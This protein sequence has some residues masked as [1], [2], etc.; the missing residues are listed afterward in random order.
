MTT[1]TG[2]LAMG[3][4]FCPGRASHG[5]SLRAVSNST[6]AVTRGIL[7]AAVVLTLCAAAPR[8]FGQLSNPGFEGL[9]NVVSISTIVA[10]LT[11]GYWGVE[12]AYVTTASY[13][14]PCEGVQMLEMK[15]TLA[16]VYTEAWQFIDVGTGSG[17]TANLSSGFN[18]FEPS[19]TGLLDLIFY[20]NNT[21]GG[22][23]NQ[24]SN[25]ATTVTLDD[26]NNAWEQ[27][28]LN[29][30]AVPDA[31]TWVGVHLGFTNASIGTGTFGLADVDAVEF[32]I[33]P[34]PATL[35]LLALGGLAVIR[36]RRK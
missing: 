33:T 34:E 6:V 36:R 20:A 29:N 16:G 17:R 30:I 19:A 13:V 3:P 5:R 12:N 18:A 11:P 35:S 22:W 15:P 26:K 27:I 10:P 28:S 8:A 4:S 9:N 14:S 24:I 23:G 7:T 32:S 31:T 21:T 1:R 2:L 25:F